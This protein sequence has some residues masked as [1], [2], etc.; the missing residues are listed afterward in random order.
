[1]EKKIV[2]FLDQPH[3]MLLERL[4]PLL[5]H[6]RKELQYKITDR[7]EKRG[8]RTKN[9][10]GYPTVIFCTGKLNPD[11]QGAESDDRREFGWALRRNVEDLLRSQ[12]VTSNGK[13]NRSQF[14]TGSRG[15]TEFEDGFIF[16]CGWRR[17]GI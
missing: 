14:V 12:N 8:L 10:K 15:G 7:S 9:V 1:M 17:T 5:S 3:F 16:L 13:A 4:R 11:E 2:I 6:D